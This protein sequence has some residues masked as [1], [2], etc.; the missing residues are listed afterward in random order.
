VHSFPESPAKPR[1]IPHDRAP[2]PVHSLAI[3]QLTDAVIAYFG[4]PSVAVKAVV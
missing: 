1:K 3:E 2:C 4:N